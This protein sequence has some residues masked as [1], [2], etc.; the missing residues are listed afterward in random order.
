MINYI[1]IAILCLSVS[2]A[3][4][5]KK[6]NKKNTNETTTAASKST[7]GASKTATNTAAAINPAHEELKAVQKELDDARKVCKTALK[8]DTAVKE[9]VKTMNDAMNKMKEEMKK[10]VPDYAAAADPK[11]AGKIFYKNRSRLIKENAAF[12]A[13]SDTYNKTRDEQ[14]KYYAGKD[15]AFK[16]VYD[17]YCKIK[18]INN[19]AKTETK[20][21]DTKKTE[22]KKK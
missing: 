18:G 11:E 7:A 4:S 21:E 2:F 19:S 8:D 16:T 5:S 3:K 22:S 20:K 15:P 12:K 9:F 6:D 10:S 1:L 17:K 13:L 14:D